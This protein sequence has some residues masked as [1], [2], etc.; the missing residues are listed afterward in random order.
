MEELRRTDSGVRTDREGTRDIRTRPDSG[1]AKRGP[2]SR[3]LAAVLMAAMIATAAFG[4][5]DP[6]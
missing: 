2:V 1:R 5:G 3:I 6:G 4:A